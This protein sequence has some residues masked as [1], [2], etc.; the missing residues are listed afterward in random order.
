MSAEEEVSGDAGAAD[1]APAED[2]GPRPR[3][4]DLVLRHK[5]KKVK[6][7]TEGEEVEEDKEG[8]GDDEEKDSDEEEEDYE[9]EDEAKKTENADEQAEWED[10]ENPKVK[11]K[12]GPA[13]RITIEAWSALRFSLKAH[14]N[15]HFMICRSITMTQ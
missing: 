12:R 9:A 5:L 7:K 1:T 3:V 11:S 13:P 2:A 15:Y 14:A 4:V 6:V 8:E 10:P